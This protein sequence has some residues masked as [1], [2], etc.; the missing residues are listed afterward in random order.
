MIRCMSRD[1][2]RSRLEVAPADRGAITTPLAGALVG[3]RLLR[4]I[5]SGERADVYLAAAEQPDAGEFHDAE[6]VPSSTGGATSVADPAAVQRPLVAVRV[7]PSQVS[8]DSVA[9]EI[10]AMSTDV[11][12]TL[13]ALHDVAALD[14]GRCCLAVER[15]AGLAVSRLLTERTLSAGEA[16]T[17]L[18]P[19]V[20]LKISAPRCWGLPI[21]GDP[22]LSVLGRAFASATSSFAF[23]A[24]TDGCTTIMLGNFAMFVMCEKSRTMS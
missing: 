19:V 21:P 16:V 10:E 4:R 9:L 5:A 17:I 20:D 11:T 23:F 15:L 14:D 2:S 24:G 6:A 22:W 7:Y 8:S 3:Y 18:A 1:R 13:P 12:G